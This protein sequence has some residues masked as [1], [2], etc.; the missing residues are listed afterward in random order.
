VAAIETVATLAREFQ[1]AAHIVHLSSAD[2]VRV[3]EAAQASGT[4]LSAE[5]CPHYL[6]FAASEIADGGTPYKCAPP[7]RSAE[8]RE[9][10]WRALKRGVCTLIASDHS[11]APS[12][13]KNV[14]I[15][16]FVTAWG[17]IASLEL[18]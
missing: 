17:G 18:S 11:P 6:T 4:T 15:G 3:V 13:L 16:D 5:A 9:E 14:E 1:V 10:L 7:I 2:G 8:H 12:A